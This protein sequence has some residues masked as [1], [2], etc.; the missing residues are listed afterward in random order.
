MNQNINRLEGLQ[1]MVMRKKGKDS[2]GRQNRYIQK[3]EFNVNNAFNNKERSVTKA[4]KE[5]FEDENIQ[6][7]YS[8]FD[9]RV[10]LCFHEHKLAIEVDEFV[11][12]DRN[13][14]YET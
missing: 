9:Y 5:V 2:Q 7:Q 3:K 4:I 1:V 14:G 6:T 12:D 11:H 8:L 10:D 13:N